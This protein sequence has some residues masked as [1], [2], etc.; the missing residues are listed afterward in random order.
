MEEREK[1]YLSEFITQKPE[2]SDFGGLREI[3]FF[4]I[5]REDEQL[6]M[7]IESG[8][9]LKCPKGTLLVREGELENYF[10]V[11]VQGKARVFKAERSLAEFSRGEIFGEMGALLYERRSADV[12]AEE[13]C[14]LFRMY[15]SAWNKLPMAVVFPMMAR[16]YRTT[17][18]RLIA[19]DQRLAVV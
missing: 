7:I 5:F 3:P 6:G 8:A 14:V 17:A 9:W 2:K 1:D 10:F 16:I 12:F 19:A 13:D 15:I 11:L 4:D 18:K